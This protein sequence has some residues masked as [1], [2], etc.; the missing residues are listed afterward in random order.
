MAATIVDRAEMSSGRQSPPPVPGCQAIQH[1]GHEP[2]KLTRK[3]TTPRFGK[4]EFA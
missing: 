4:V 1:H 2:K 3:R